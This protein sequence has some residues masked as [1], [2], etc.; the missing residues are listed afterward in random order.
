MW[1]NRKAS[2]SGKLER[3][4][5]ITSLRTSAVRLRSTTGT[6]EAGASSRT[7]SR[8]NTVPSTEIRASS[9]RSSSGS[10]SRRAASRA[11]IVG[12]T[13]SSPGA[14]TSVQRPS[15]CWSS[16][17]SISIASSSSTKSGL[18]SQASA[19]RRGLLARKLPRLSRFSTS[20]LLSS[21]ASGS[22]RIEVAFSLPPPQ[23]GRCVEQLGAAPCR[24]ARSARRATRSATCSTRSR[25]VGS[26]HWRSSS[27]TTSGRGACQRLEQPASRPEDLLAG[28]ERRLRRGRPPRPRPS[29]SARP[30]APR[31]AR[32]P[33]ASRSA[34][35]CPSSS[36]SM[37]SR[38]ISP[39][40]Q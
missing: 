4:G 9:A 24:A 12:G 6:S 5:R 27:T 23:P 39:S 25:K 35:P 40:G 32:S 15:S 21:G 13:G 26:A 19:M 10:R 29:R 17:S 20:S 30:S 16:R 2:S 7:A 36:T 1:R 33:I 28:A 22:S 11:W 34:A 3:S 18:P 37:R 31:P 8:W 14:S 38:T